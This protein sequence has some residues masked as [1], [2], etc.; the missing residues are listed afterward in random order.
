MSDSPTQTRLMLEKAQLIATCV[1]LVGS[2]VYIG[3]RSEQD[4]AQSRVLNSIA[5]DI[6]V[7]KERNADANAQIRVIGER[8]SQVEKRLERMEQPR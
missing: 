1:L 3:R 8:V 6:T 4:E 7:M 5:A 2:L